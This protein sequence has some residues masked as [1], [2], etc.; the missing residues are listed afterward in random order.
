M[1]TLT[2]IRHAK[3]T[4]EH[5]D[6]DDI[7]RPL[8]SEGRRDAVIMG[9]VLSKRGFN[10][11]LIISSPALRTIRTAEAITSAIKCSET[12]IL[13]DEK[14]YLAGPDEI[15]KSV[16]S[17]GNT[18][19]WLVCVGHNPGIS[20]FINRLLNS[21]VDSLPTCGIVEMQFD[22]DEWDSIEQSNL[23]H[24]SFDYPKKYRRNK[25]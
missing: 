8:D 19:D 6:I 11:D 23:L 17:V 2:M 7:D 4:W 14:L 20:D 21:R 1:K 10:P 24:S 12:S 5:H 22:T 13:M 25:I 3:S 15:L 18:V 9:K 16:Q